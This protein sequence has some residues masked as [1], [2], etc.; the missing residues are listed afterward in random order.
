MDLKIREWIAGIA[1]ALCG[2]AIAADIE[3]PNGYAIVESQPNEHSIVRNAEVILFG[4]VEQYGVVGTTVFGFVTK[5]SAPTAE[6]SYYD[7][8]RVGHFFL[9]TRTGMLATGLDEKSWT[10][11]LSKF[12]VS[13]TPVLKSTCADK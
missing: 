1:M 6:P 8:V 12:G 5:P 10:I 4:N 3:L 13:K 11:L 7:D 2:S 9:D